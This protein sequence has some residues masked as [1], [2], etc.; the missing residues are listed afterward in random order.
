MKKGLLALFI[1]MAA[2]TTYAGELGDF[3]KKAKTSG[4]SSSKE[5]SDNHKKSDSN[6]KSGSN[7]KDKESNGIYDIFAALAIDM[8][9]GGGQSSFMKAQTV[10]TGKPVTGPFFSVSPKLLGDRLIPFARFDYYGAE[11]SSNVYLKDTTLELG[12]G[13]FSAYGKES[14]FV[15]R[16]SGDELTL[17]Q[18]FIDYRML[19]TNQ[20]QLSI[21]TGKYQMRGNSKT[22]QDAARL[23]IT[24][25]LIDGLYFDY[26]Y[27]KSKGSQFSI[28]DQEASFT[29]A[30]KNIGLKAGY[31]KVD[32]AGAE[33]TG[34]FAGITLQF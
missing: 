31:R 2:F 28:I 24:T 13:A 22:T 21:G 15:E 4:S 9:V 10:F 29:Y 5:K 26:S 11:I 3:E 7:A 8:I 16:D 14:L 25:K 33:L 20:F 18:W 1:I 23:G 12:Y 34:P 27:L 17:R 32:T 30:F 6:K 19:L